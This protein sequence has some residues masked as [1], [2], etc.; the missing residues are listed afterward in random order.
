MSTLDSTA[1]D[2]NDFVKRAE[3]YYDLNLRKQ[4]EA[5]HLHEFVAIDPETGTFFLA[6]TLNE[7]TK[8]ARTSLPGK[9]THAI[10]IGHVGAVQLGMWR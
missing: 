10:R 4:L 7:A 8:A 9:R 6:K 1:F 2:L 5:E 3:A